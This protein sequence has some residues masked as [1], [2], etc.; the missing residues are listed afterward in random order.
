MFAIPSNPIFRDVPGRP[1]RIRF[2][3]GLI[4]ANL[5][6]SFVNYFL[7]NIAYLIIQSKFI[8]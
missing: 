8:I 3:I 6:V 5:K 2:W 4:D 1:S 7:Q